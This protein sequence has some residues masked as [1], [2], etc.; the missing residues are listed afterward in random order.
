MEY[1]F[2]DIAYNSIAKKKPEESDKNCYIGLEHL[3][4]DCLDI[5]RWG[6]ETAPTGEKLI[7]KKG[8]VL[9]GKRRAYQREVGIAPFDGIFSAH[10]MVLRPKENVIDKDYFPFF[11]SSDMFMERAVRI[12][13]GGLSPTINWKDLKIQEFTLPPLPE[14]KVLAEKLWAAYRLK[15]AY[16]KL[17]AATD[18][19]V[20]AKFV[21]MLKASKTQLSLESLCTYLGKGITAKYVEKSSINVI[22]QACI[23]RDGLRFENVKYHNEDV[24]I[25]KRVLQTGDVLLNATGSGTLGRS[26]VFKCPSNN[27]IYIN[28]SHVI[29]MK[30]NE[31]LIY[32]EILNTYLSLP[33]TQDEIYNHY[34]TGSTNQIDIV[35]TK[36][37]SM[38]IP[39]PAMVEQISFVKMLN[40]AETSK[41]ALQKS[42]E[43]IDLVIKSLINQ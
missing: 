35:F 8:D 34:V 5:T 7:M 25:K 3:D 27:D 28:D 31:E 32:P 12:S 19:M 10:G 33:D 38:M 15:E 4:S 43:S 36:I 16:K 1:K 29:S 37:K 14:Q 42:I 17:L 6:A 41:T 13:V 40:Q 23:Y 18:E 30:T 21:E 20:K 11:I 9:F 22:N 24:A 2:E 26:C 39:I